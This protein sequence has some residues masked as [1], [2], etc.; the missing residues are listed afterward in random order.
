MAT[1]KIPAI[2]DPE[3]KGSPMEL[4]KNI[5][6]IVNILRMLG[7]NSLNMNNNNKILP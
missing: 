6:E 1:N 5:S 4:T 7:A 3:L 2:T